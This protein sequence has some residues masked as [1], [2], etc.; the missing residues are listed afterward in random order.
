MGTLQDSR[1]RGGQIG[2]CLW[3][4]CDDVGSLQKKLGDRTAQD[5]EAEEAVGPVA[6]S[7]KQ[8]N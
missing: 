1:N 3:S 7:S 6:D 2:N 4:N 8:G 5:R